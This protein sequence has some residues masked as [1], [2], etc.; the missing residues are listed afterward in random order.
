MN[1]KKTNEENISRLAYNPGNIQSIKI[2]FVADNDRFPNLHFK[3]KNGEEFIIDM[4]LQDIPNI[5]R[6]FCGNLLLEKK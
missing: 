4:K 5:I 2:N 6:V 3:Y 1:D